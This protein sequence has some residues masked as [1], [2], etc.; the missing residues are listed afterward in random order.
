M[1]ELFNRD[2][3]VDGPEVVLPLTDELTT[4]AQLA[5]I[6]ED[7]AREL[8]SGER[9]VGPGYDSN[10]I[11]VLIEGDHASVL[12]CSRDNGEL[13]SA[14]G[15]LITPAATIFKTRE[16]RLVRVDDVWLVEDFVSGR[17]VECDPDA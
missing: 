7:I 1:T 10:I 6:R 16:T 2:E 11:D 4:G 15:E 13:Y 12:D 5:R 8:A 14:E 3:R 9:L 17:G